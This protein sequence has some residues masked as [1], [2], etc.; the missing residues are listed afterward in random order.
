MWGHHVYALAFY[1]VLVTVMLL[2]SSQKSRSCDKTS[3]YCVMMRSR[4]LFNMK[5]RNWVAGFQRIKSH[6]VNRR[7]VENA[8][9]LKLVEPLLSLPNSVARAARA[10]AGR[11]TGRPARARAARATGLGRLNK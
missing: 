8:L 1:S 3:F 9:K 4:K 7:K 5:A 2:R 11:Y 10:L 6:S